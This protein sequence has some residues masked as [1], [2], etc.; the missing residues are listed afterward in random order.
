MKLLLNSILLFFFSFL[1][2]GSENFRQPFNSVDLIGI[3]KSFGRQKLV[4]VNCPPKIYDGILF[5]LKDESIIYSISEGVVD[6]IS[7]IENRF[8]GN[9]IDIRVQ[10]SIVVTYYHLSSIFVKK[11]EK[12]NITTE[13]G[14]SGKTG[15]TIVNGLGLK[16]R[17]NDSIVDPYQYLN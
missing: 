13:L 8:L 9:F 10:D 17:I 16:V 5:E 4:S 1:N 3:N 6:S 7:L 15:Y 11:G 14:I 2:Q 12:I